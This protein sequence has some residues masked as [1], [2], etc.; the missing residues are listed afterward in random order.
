MRILM[1]NYE[2]PPVGGGAANATYYLLKEFSKDSNIEIDLITSSTSE[3]KFEVFSENI[4]IYKL[5]VK[6]ENR[7]YW[8]MAELLRWSLKAYFLSKKLARKNRYGLCHCWFGWP[9]GFIGYKLRKDMDYIVALRGSDVPG[10]NPRLKMIDN[11]FLRTVSR[12]IWANSKKVIANSQGLK[13]LASATLDRDIDIIHNGIDVEGF[14][15]DFKIKKELRILSTS[16]L[17]RRKG[18]EYLINAVF[19]LENIRLDIVGDGNLRNK[20][21]NLSAKLNLGNKVFFHGNIPHNQLKSFYQ[22]ADVFVLP[23]LNEGMS[24]SLLEA[25]ASGLAVI[26]TDTGG[27]KELIKDNGF[28]VEKGSPESIAHKLKLLERDRGLA[29]SMG[30][31][32]RNAAKNINWK[33]AAKKYKGVYNELA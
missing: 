19:D 12:K 6:K 27:T 9:C 11:L 7:H 15:P 31:K 3:F 17:I 1:L 28:V 30:K 20:L 23:S 14:N 10:Y 18:I 5:D 22:N 29:V 26:A 32:S 16:R 4:R 13:K 24:N 2:F 25:M 33:N 21:E 8:K